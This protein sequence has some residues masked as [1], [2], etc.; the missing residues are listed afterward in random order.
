VPGRLNTSARA[1]LVLGA[2]IAAAPGWCIEVGD[3]RIYTCEAGDCTNGFGKARSAVTN[4]LY[5]G[6]WS[7]GKS[8]AGQTYQLSHPA[9]ERVYKATFAANGLQDS[10]D[11]LFGGGLMSRALPVFTGSYA[12]VDHPFAQRKV[13]VPRR[14]QLD[15]GLGFVYAGRFEYLPAKVTLH[16]RL[17]SGSYVFF[18]T[19]T[20]TEDDSKE[21]GLF[22]TDVQANGMAPRFQKA[23]AA[24]L[25]KL[26]QR[27]QEELEAGK[28]FIAEQEASMRWREALAVIG[29]LGMA[30]ATAGV[31]QAVQGL[32]S[33]AAMNVMN[34]MLKS[35]DGKLTA[36]D[37]TN[38]AIEQVAASDDEARRQLR[39]LLR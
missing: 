39:G 36:E 35:A 13:A 33:E 20:D 34:N 17:V 9:S 32:A 6:T 25:A 18:G 5:E 29:K 23:N 37:A 2:A 24:F 11:L 10:G 4:V 22:L 27:Y 30:L 15:T 1:G 16:T 3:P 8:I 12:H 31:S 21:T 38:Q 26:Q 28:V 19:V 7:G 14:G